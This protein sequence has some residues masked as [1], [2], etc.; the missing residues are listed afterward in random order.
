MSWKWIED[1]ED[2]YKIYPD[3]NVESYYS[4]TPRMLKPR[5][6]AYGYKYVRLYKNG[7]RKLHKIH[8][9]LAKHFIENP[10]PIDFLVVD[11]IDRN[12]LNNNLENLRWATISIN[13]RNKKSTGKY[14][15]G[16]SKTANGKRF[17]VQIRINGKSKYLGTFDTELEANEV[18]MKKYNKIMEDF[19][20]L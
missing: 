20:N 9:L 7:E 4:K 1:Y 17:K 12:K 11:H 5:I 13:C 8:R 16:V 15:R 10:N 18:Y 14:M 3:G 6:D 19:N 2:L